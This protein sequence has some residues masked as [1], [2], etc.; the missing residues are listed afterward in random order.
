M[1]SVADRTAPTDAHADV[2]G[3]VR[4][5]NR[6]RRV[7]FVA[8]PLLAGAVTAALFS[9][10]PVQY[11]STLRVVVSREL[12]SSASGIGLYL[13][14][15]QLQVLQPDVVARVSE[16]TGVGAREYQNGIGLHRVGQSRSADFTFT[17]D[18]PETASAVVET[19]ASAGLRSLATEGLPFAKREVELAEQSYADAVRGLN[20]FRQRHGVAYPEEQYQQAITDLEA[21][22]AEHEQAEA[23]GDA[24]EIERIAAAQAELTNTLESL[25][26]LLP[27]YEKLN[28]ARTVALELR[29]AARDRLASKRAEIR[30]TRPENV[31][32]DIMTTALSRTQRA[33]QGAV[34]SMAAAL[35]LLFVVFVLPDLFRVPRGSRQP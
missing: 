22:K 24:A 19:A 20:A 33:L 26:E 11:E 16:Q 4:T 7:L 9:R 3:P 21:V 34:V 23:I 10:Q 18:D 15:L 1:T 28:D 13:A 14:D 27:Q 25:K 29:S 5:R 6:A 8:I 32:R 12:S 35:F 31:R 2:V 17:S 30:L